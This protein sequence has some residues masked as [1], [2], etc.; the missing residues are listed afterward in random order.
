MD[1]PEKHLETQLPPI[2][3]LY[4]SLNNE[5][6]SQEEYANV[7]EIWD[8]F[9]IKNLQEFTQLYNK[10]DILLLTCYGKL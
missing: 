2:E 6:V 8:K 5:N 7:Q 9:Q 4:S 10:V 1:S 3:K